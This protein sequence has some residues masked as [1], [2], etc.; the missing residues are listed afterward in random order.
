MKP[1]G[2]P[3]VLIVGPSASGK[4]AV[5]NFLGG[6][7]DSLELEG[8]EPT[9]GCRIVEVERDVSGRGTVSAELWDVSGDPR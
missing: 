1:S 4:S 8:H 5:A 7:T 6:V 2:K 9:S 3:K